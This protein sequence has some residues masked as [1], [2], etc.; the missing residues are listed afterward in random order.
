M[1]QESPNTDMNYTNSWYSITPNRLLVTL[2]ALKGEINCDVCVIGGGFTG[3][4]AALELVSKG[5]S[6]TILESRNL[7]ESSTA[8]NG[9]HIIRGYHHSPGELASKYGAAKA[10][11]MN[12][13][14]MEGLA[15]IIERIIKHQIKCDLKFGHVTAALTPEHVS[16]LK[17]LQNEWAKAGHADLKYI[18]GDELPDYVFSPK[19]IGGL[20]DPK[21]A[22]FHPLNYALGLI[23]VMQSAGCKIYDETPVVS[24][25]KGPV[26]R[27]I[28]EKGAVNA[29]FL[30]LS[31]YLRIS[32]LPLLNKYIMPSWLRMLATQPLGDQYS[33]KILPRNSAVMDSNRL[34]N[35]F[36]LSHDNR[37]IFGSF[38]P[39][40]NLRERMI[41]VFPNLTNAT[42]EHEW[43]S[44][45]DFT[46]NHMPCMG[47]YA[48]NIFYAHGYCRHG[49]ILGN[50]AGKLIAEA[51]SG[52]A[53]RFDVF[54]K[55]RHLPIPGGDDFKVRLVALAQAWYKMKDKI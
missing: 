39:H 12:N 40:D 52:T 34:M 26:A 45:M 20:F 55:I 29:K 7:V 42:I 43:R 1:P 28:T 27:V 13:M 44:P 54:S 19:Y 36:K 23:Q 38:S 48:A 49:V 4:S 53:E 50:L 25:Q 18:D 3:L 10:K 22:H 46:L 41:E 11:M 47:R 37:L 24:I 8:K 32:G 33:H 16:K 30:V 35:F 14:T 2:G 31:G 15:L 9:T 21:G 17:R 5:Y 51:V 6:V